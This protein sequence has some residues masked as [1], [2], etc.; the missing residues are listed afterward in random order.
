MSGFKETISKYIYL[1]LK[2]GEVNTLLDFV[3]SDSKR[4]RLI[5]HHAGKLNS[6][7][8]NT[9]Q[10]KH[11]REKVL[12]SYNPDSYLTFIETVFPFSASEKSIPHEQSLKGVQD[13]LLAE[14][15]AYLV[16][17]LSDDVN[18]AILP[19]QK[20]AYIQDTINYFNTLNQEN[21]MIGFGDAIKEYLKTTHT[22]D[23]GKVLKTGYPTLDGAL[24]GLFPGDL[25]S[26][27]APTGT[28][29]T[30]LGL[31]IMKNI[32]D[33]GGKVMVMSLEMD[34]RELYSRF[35]SLY[36]GNDPKSY[37]AMKF[38]EKDKNII[39]DYFDKVI[40]TR[41]LN[42][43]LFLKRAY[44]LNF[45]LIEK[46]IE[47]HKPDA[48]L[49]DSVYNLVSKSDAKHGDYVYVF[50]GC[51]AL[52]L[53]YKIPVIITSQLSGDDAKASRKGSKPPPEAAAFSKALA[54]ESSV[55]ITMQDIVDDGTSFCYSNY[56]E[57]EITL[58]K[59]RHSQGNISF[60]IKYVIGNDLG[61][62]CLDEVDTEKE[63]VY[64]EET[65]GLENIL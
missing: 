51:K 61:E 43:C 56:M 52:G 19:A 38:D 49:L 46:Y 2:E 35:A 21:G 60:K 50:R 40:G 30:W 64:I 36:T 53:K 22:L 32:Y 44:G 10:D 29:K 42:D 47:E 39:L 8:L 13:A 3:N 11:N 34:A 24:L 57:K 5:F 9:I 17:N 6:D 12:T 48:I 65:D 28:G 16:Q 41:R 55:M 7:R 62:T 31:N 59:S 18:N 45:T 1:C 23:D 26:V 63:E 25:V 15:L 20:L 58:A 37:M 14:I 54:H 33:Q 27:I 4:K